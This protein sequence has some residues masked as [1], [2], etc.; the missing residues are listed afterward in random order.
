ME[1]ARRRCRTCAGWRARPKVTAPQALHRAG[2][3]PG[4]RRTAHTT[5]FARARLPL[6][7]QPRDGCARHACRLVWQIAPS[8]QSDGLL[9]DARPPADR[10]R[11][12]CPPAMPCR[13]WSTATASFRHHRH[14]FSLASIPRAPGGVGCGHRG[15]ARTAWRSARSGRSRSDSAVEAVPAAH[16][17]RAQRGERSCHE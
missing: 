8:G 10:R 13:K 12:L 6:R 2:S 1:L 17:D 16:Y 9:S 4:G 11:A 3:V 14:A 7:R 5:R 15:G